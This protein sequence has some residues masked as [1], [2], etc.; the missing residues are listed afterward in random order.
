M[1][2]LVDLLRRDLS[3]AEL[4]L[5]SGHLDEPRQEAAVVDERQPLVE[6]PVHVLQPVHA[7]ARLAAQEY[8][9][10]LV[11]RWDET[12]QENITASTVVALQ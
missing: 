12:Q 1:L 7:E 2:H 8:D 10:T 6:V 4:L 3:D 11:S 5:L 9:H